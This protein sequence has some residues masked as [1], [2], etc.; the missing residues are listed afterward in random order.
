MNSQYND[1]IKLKLH[2]YEI[3]LKFP[4]QELELDRLDLSDAE[5]ELQQTSPL[6][7]IRQKDFIFKLQKSKG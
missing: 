2:N 6:L 4:N 3:K 5:L 7:V 1:V